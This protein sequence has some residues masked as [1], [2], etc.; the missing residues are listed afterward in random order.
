MYEM[1]IGRTAFQFHEIIFP[2]RIF[3]RGKWE[4]DFL[5]ISFHL[6]RHNMSYAYDSYQWWQL[7]YVSNLKPVMFN[8]SSGIPQPHRAV[9]CCKSAH[10]ICLT[11]DKK[12]PF[13]LKHLLGDDASTDQIWIWV[14]QMGVIF[15]CSWSGKQYITCHVTHTHAHGLPIPEITG[16]RDKIVH[17]N[18]RMQEHMQSIYTP[19]HNLKIWLDWFWSYLFDDL[20]IASACQHF[21]CEVRKESVGPFEM[22]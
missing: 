12:T 13:S 5:K 15:I 17:Q 2:S 16:R 11:V 21:I 1:R 9:H 19:A 4:F 20:Q 8:Y 10:R 22:K 7:P 3:W 18:S 14:V 6:F